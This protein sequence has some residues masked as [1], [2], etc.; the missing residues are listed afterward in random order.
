MNSPDTLA[1][2]QKQLDEAR[3]AQEAANRRIAE[4]YDRQRELARI[5]AEEK[6]RADILEAERV[7]KLEQESPRE[8]RVKLFEHLNVGVTLL[9]DTRSDILEILR[10]TPGWQ[11]NAYTQITWLPVDAWESVREKLKALPNVKVTHLLGMQEKID[12]YLHGPE[13]TIQLFEKYLQISYHP[14]AISGVLSAIPGIRWKAE[15]YSCQVPISE[16]WR[17]LDIFEGYTRQGEKKHIFWDTK[18]LAI[19]QEEIERRVALDKVVLEQDTDL[20]NPFK[21]GHELRPFQKVGVKF[22]KLSK[23]R[24]LLADQMGLGKTWQAIAYAMSENLRVVVICPAHLKAN[25]AREI[26][27]LTDEM[28]FILSGREPDEFTIKKMLLDKPRYSIINYDILGFKTVQPMQDRKNEDGTI[29]RIPAKDRFLWAELI[30]MSKPDLVILDEAHYIKN[31]SANRTRAI[32]G[33]QPEH[34]LPMTG[35]PVLN[36]IGEYFSVLH[37]VRPDVFPSEERFY[38]DYTLD[39]KTPKN[40]NSLRDIL[41]PVM[42]RRLKKDV[43]A[44]L[45][46]L[47]RIT[48][49]HELSEAAILEYRK[50][51]AGVYRAID[52]AG[53]HVERNIT[54]ILTEIGKL[55]EVC[56]RDK[57]QHT[58]DLAIELYETEQDADDAKGGRKKVLIFS[59][60]KETTRLIAERLGASARFWTGDTPMEKRTE[61]E[62]QFQTDPNVKFLVVSLMTGQ[63]GLNLTAAGHVIFNDLYWTPAAHAQAEERAYGRLSDLHGADSYYVVAQNTIEDWIQELLQGKMNLINMTVEGIDAE[64]DVSVGMAIIQRLKEARGML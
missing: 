46:P 10:A 37:W 45:P 56:A 57:I 25:W 6:R 4:L 59:Q 42:I 50:V 41:K 52:E 51:L 7:R 62:R 63:T 44:D 19:V 31:T 13:F 49:T 5:E 18:A 14:R 2:I 23:G 16:G 33:I 54:S 9:P 40:L 11:F 12:K 30:A 24:T 61:L 22:I 32:L 43:V 27:Q 53:N 36:R 60:F 8:V 3:L 34:R 38:R 17:L 20:V 58:V 48:E 64:R 15:D 29:T 39:G 1:D 55:K 26:K 35:T 21:N 28:A 47:N